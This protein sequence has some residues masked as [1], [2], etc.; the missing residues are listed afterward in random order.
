M[1]FSSARAWEG[2]QEELL[3]DVRLLAVSK[4][5]LAVQNDDTWE[6]VSKVLCLLCAFSKHQQTFHLIFFFNILLAFFS[7]CRVSV[8]ILF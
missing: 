2:D 7:D 6:K 1:Q 3:S 5:I 4:K 8:Q